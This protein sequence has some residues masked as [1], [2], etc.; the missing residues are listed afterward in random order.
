MILT[1]LSP[2]IPERASITL[3]R[4]FCEKF[5]EIPGSRES[6]SVFM[7][8]TSSSFVRARAGPK[9]QY[10]QPEFLINS[11]QSRSGRSGTKY[12]LL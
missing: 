7:A 4:I 11:G 2:L 8:A 3:S 1:E 10:L 5:Q 12:S 9:T 6:S